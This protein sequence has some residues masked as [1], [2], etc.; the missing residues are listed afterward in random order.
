VRHGAV[1]GKGKA[2][3][4]GKNK[5]GRDLKM[6]KLYAR[7]L[8]NAAVAFSTS[9]LS[10]NMVTEGRLFPLAVVVGLTTAS[11]QAV[12]AAGIELKKYGDN[13]ESKKESVRRAVM[14]F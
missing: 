11:L 2:D 5:N 3:T 13:G 4:K 7:I 9:F 6:N 8:G 12:L 14:L 1:A 10:V